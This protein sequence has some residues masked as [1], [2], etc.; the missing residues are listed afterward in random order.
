MSVEA[1]VRT[2]A[3]MCVAILTY[4]AALKDVDVQLPAHVAWLERNYAEGRILLSGRRQPRTGGVI[5]F[6]GAK[7]EV[8][9]LTATDP[10]VLAGVA[11]TE[12]VPFTASMAG[13]KLR[14][15]FE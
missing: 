9:A 4:V 15:L 7:D 12:V 8:E 14:G 13:S 1:F 3:P 5:L 6:R 2:D 11:T 10:F